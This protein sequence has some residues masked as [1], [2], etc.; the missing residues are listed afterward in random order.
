M[1]LAGK[2]CNPN[3][4]KQSRFKTG[5]HCIDIYF[6]SQ[7]WMLCPKA[8]ISHKGESSLAKKK[9]KKRFQSC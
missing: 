9:K 2:L 5:I 8:D 7:L 4:T 1:G 6:C 3:L